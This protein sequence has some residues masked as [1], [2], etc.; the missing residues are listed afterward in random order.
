MTHLESETWAV[1]SSD[2]FF[3][4]CWTPLFYLDILLFFLWQPAFLKVR[5]RVILLPS[6]ACSPS[7]LNEPCNLLASYFAHFNYV[8]GHSMCDIDRTCETFSGFWDLPFTKK[9]LSL[10]EI[11]LS[12]SAR[13]KKK[14]W[15][16]DSNITILY[17]WIV[18]KNFFWNKKCLTHMKVHTCSLTMLTQI[19]W[20]SRQ[21]EHRFTA[22]TCTS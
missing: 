16:E 8:V 7:N 5:P 22:P 12:S 9:L 6:P 3:G 20:A 17:P 18:F 11:G 10:K 19:F 13:L 21:K 1:C 4:N 2:F 15:E 14:K